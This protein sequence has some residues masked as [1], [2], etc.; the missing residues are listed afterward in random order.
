MTGVVRPALKTVPGLADV[1]VWGGQAKQIHVILDPARVREFGLT[2][3][4]LAQAVERNNANGSGSLI[5]VGP[6]QEV[7]RTLGMLQTSED[8]RQ[9]VVGQH[10][11]VP[12]LLGQVGTVQEGSLTRQGAV[13]ANGT[14]EEVYGIALLLLGENGR[15]VVE[16]VKERLRQIEPAL[17]PG[18]RLEGFLDR[19]RD[20]CHPGHGRA[21]PGRGWLAG[22]R[23]ALSS[24]CKFAPA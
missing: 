5:R 4:Q 8:V 3:Q 6:E 18:S 21:Q 9:I 14:G 17:P 2:F 7:V 19:P 11:S 24:C 15:V 1:N 12:L 10:N 20:P 16:R 22:S 23:A 13:S